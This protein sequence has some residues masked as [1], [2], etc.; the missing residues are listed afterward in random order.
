[1]PLVPLAPL[2]PLVPKPLVP[3]LPLVPPVPLVPLVPLLPL[4]LPSSE[5]L[6]HASSVPRP[7]TGTRTRDARAVR[8]E[9]I[10]VHHDRLTGDPARDLDR[11]AI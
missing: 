2:V 3:L 8:K 7:R 4:E 5:L 10:Y 11:Y 1:V 9:L 6:P